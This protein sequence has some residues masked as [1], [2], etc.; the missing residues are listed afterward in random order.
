ML[1]ENPETDHE[2]WKCLKSILPQQEGSAW[3]LGEAAE[4]VLRPSEIER[5]ALPR[6][7]L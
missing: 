5:C 3:G 4:S 6:L 1:R 2:K 7:G